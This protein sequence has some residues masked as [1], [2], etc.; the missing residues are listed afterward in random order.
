M[1]IIVSAK[2]HVKLDSHFWWKSQLKGIEE[3]K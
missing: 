1:V 2:I 3:T